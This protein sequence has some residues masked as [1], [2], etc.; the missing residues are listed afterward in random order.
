M[1]LDSFEYIAVLDPAGSP[2]DVFSKSLHINHCDLTEVYGRTSSRFINARLLFSYLKKNNIKKCL[3]LQSNRSGEL[4]RDYYSEFIPDGCVLFVVSCRQK[5]KVISENIII[6]EVPDGL[7][8]AQFDLKVGAHF[9]VLLK[10]Q[11]SSKFNPESLQFPPHVGVLKSMED[12]V[13]QGSPRGEAR[14]SIGDVNFD[15]VFNIKSATK[16]IVVVE[17]AALKRHLESPPVYHRW[18]W[19]D[20]FNATTLVINDPTLYLNERLNGG[21]W[22]G[23]KSNDYVK[24]FV[25]ALEGFAKLLGVKS[26]NIVFYGGSAGGYSAFQMAS[27]LPGSVVIADIPQTNLNSYTYPDQINDAFAAGFGEDFSAENKVDFSCRLDVIDRFSSEGVVPDFIY[28]QNVNDHSHVEHQ[29]L[30]FIDRVRGMNKSKKGYAARYFIYD[31]YHPQRGGHTPLGRYATTKIVNQ[32][33]AHG[34]RGFRPDADL[35]LREFSV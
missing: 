32:V 22:I 26:R 30:P 35:F 1:T 11:T 18:K 4:S 27:C 9:S 25:S 5:T 19:A 33:L 14:V 31:I 21:W 29:M 20:S 24:T 12:V 7:N 16:K 6:Q 8:A 34:V 3:I 10:K 17:Q 13:N 15:F 2:F 23:T 28:L